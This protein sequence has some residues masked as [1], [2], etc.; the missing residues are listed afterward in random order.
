[1][2][3]YQLLLAASPPGVL[4]GPAPASAASSSAGSPPPVASRRRS[5]V[6]SAAPTPPTAWTHAR[7]YLARMRLRSPRA[8]PPQR[9]PA[10]LL[11]PDEGLRPPVRHLDRTGTVRGFRVRYVRGRADGLLPLLRTVA[12]GID[13][14]RRSS[15]CWIRGKTTA[16]SAAGTPAFTASTP[17]KLETVRRDSSFRFVFDS[18]GA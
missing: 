10:R 12:T 14:G 5:A 8:R 6:A 15:S 3:V 4:R 7:T 13:D 16:R 9:P 1:M 2:D 17:P 11:P 18:H